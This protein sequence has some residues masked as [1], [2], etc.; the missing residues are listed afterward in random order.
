MPHVAHT[1]PCK[2]C[3]FR[4]ASAAGWLGSATPEEFIAS[5]LAEYDMPCHLAIDYEAKDWPDQVEAGP[6]C[7]G[8]LIFLK[9]VCHLPRRPALRKATEAVEADRGAVFANRQEFL[10]YHKRA[11]GGP[12]TLKLE[13]PSVP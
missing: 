7:A 4:R 6:R 2:E 3:P 5:T 1:K 12:V 11:S 13:A 10:D 8:S 9:N